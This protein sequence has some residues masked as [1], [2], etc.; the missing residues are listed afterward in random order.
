VS[1]PSPTA[2][3]PPSTEDRSPATAALRAYFTSGWAFFIP[4]LLIYLLYYWRK[5]PANSFAPLA[6][7]H[8]GYIP[9]LLHV[10]WALHVIN[11]VLAVIALRS[12]WRDAKREEQRAKGKESTPGPHVTSLPSSSVNGPPSTVSPPPSSADR[13]PSTVHGAALRAA[14]PWLFLILIFAIPGIYLE[15]PSDPWEHLRRI[16]EWNIHPLVGNHSAGYKSFYFFAYSWIGW[17]TPAHLLSWLNVYYVGVCLL[18]AWQYYR[19]AKA[20]GLDQRWAFLFVVINALTFGNSC[21][22]FYR[23][24]GIS[25]S[26]YAQLGAVALTRIVLEWAKGKGGRAKSKEQR[27]KGK[28]RGAW[29]EENDKSLRLWRLPLAILRAARAAAVPLWLGRFALCALLLTFI[30][31]NHLQGIGIVGLSIGAIIAWRLIEWK[32]SMIFWLSAAAVTLSIATILWWPRNP[33]IYSTFRAQG[34]LNAWYGFNL[35]SWPSPAADRMMQILGLVGLANLM[36]GVFLLR[37]NSLIG[38]LTVGPVIGLALP[39]VAIPFSASIAG[40]IIAYHR[41]F[42]ATPPNLAIVM[43]A[44]LYCVGIYR[45]RLSPSRREPPTLRFAGIAVGICLCV[46]VLIPSPGPWFNRTWQVLAV[47]PADLTLQTVVD[48]AQRSAI[49]A[50]HENPPLLVSTDAVA[51]IFDTIDPM[52]FAYVDRRSLIGQPIMHSLQHAVATVFSSRDFS[53][54]ASMTADPFVTGISHWVSLYGVAPQLIGNLSNLNG[55]TSALQS[56][57]GQRTDVFTSELIPIEPR[58]IYRTQLTIIRRS[59]RNVRAYL[60]LAWYDQDGRLLESN[61]PSPAGAGSPS[62]WTNG[63]YSY[64]GLING[65]VPADWTTYRRAFGKGKMA[66]I[67]SNAKYVRIGALLN[68][69][70]SPDAVVQLTKIKLWREEGT[71]PSTD[72]AL[73]TNERLLIVA[74]KARAASTFYSQAALAST[75]WPANQVASDSSGKL[76]L[77]AAA[78][79]GNAN[80]VGPIEAIIDPKE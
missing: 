46:F 43:I 63:T 73:S 28:G 15:W 69:G 79:I 37:R 19:F 74:P 23:Y 45:D 47:T 70:H 24:Y 36:V 5:W 9:A 55:I 61:I 50:E 66:T 31:F 12:W 62:G 53:N 44:R 26:I 77:E 57:R 67:P 40:E 16:T 39:V 33:A 4:Y 58:Q 17:L 56:P 1:L 51:D 21:F 34:W 27:A 29:S 71:E 30:A 32:R 64:F 49:L 10:Y 11:A 75:H 25:T 42:F 54:Q 20:V 80:Y 76:Q 8:G 14:A 59:G 52:H 48:A 68:Y 18:L 13:Q 3:C 41:M 22:S 7:G 38:W 72:V 6:L 60:A 2:H 35:F 78:R 65:R